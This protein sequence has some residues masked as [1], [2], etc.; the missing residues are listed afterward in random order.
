MPLRKFLPPYRAAALPCGAKPLRTGAR[1]SALSA[2]AI[3]RIA[4]VP[5]PQANDAE[6][7]ISERDLVA[8]LVR[9]LPAELALVAWLF[10][11]DGL[12][13]A[14][15]AEICGVSRRT[16]ISRLNRFS[17]RARSFLKR[18]DDGRRR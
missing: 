7:A 8:R 2:R 10:H 1:D 18:S 12:E 11:V 9:E 5:A 3:S 15:I 6:R 13:Q 17:E 14:E 4:A 16:I